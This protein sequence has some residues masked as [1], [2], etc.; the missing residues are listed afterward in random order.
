MIEPEL[1]ARIAKLKNLI[2]DG[3]VDSEKAENGMS[4]NF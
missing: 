1:Q 2:D 3:V 4:S